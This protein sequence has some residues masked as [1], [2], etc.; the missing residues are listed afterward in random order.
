MICPY[1]KFTDARVLETRSS[2]QKIIRTQRKY[3]C[4]NCEK[5]YVSSII[6]PENLKIALTMPLE[7][8]IKEFS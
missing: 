7:I 4:L 5:I 1:C 8:D 3:Q 2:K 6:T